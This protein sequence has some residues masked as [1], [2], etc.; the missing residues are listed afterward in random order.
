MNTPDFVR[1]FEAEHQGIWTFLTSVILIAN[2]CRKLVITN[3]QSNSILLTYLNLCAMLISMFVSVKWLEI[4]QRVKNTIRSV[5]EAAAVAHPEMHSS[6][7]R[8]MYGVD[9]MLDSSFQPKL[10]EVCNVS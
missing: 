3:S 6:K 10:L 1:G 9:I 4:H 8:A 5:F 7:S 2:Q